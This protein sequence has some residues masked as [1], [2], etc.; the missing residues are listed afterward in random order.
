MRRLFLKDEEVA[1]I[2]SPT[3]I[4]INC[5]EPE[6]ILSNKVAEI[7]LVFEILKLCI[8]NKDMEFARFFHKKLKEYL[9]KA[10]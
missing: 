5:I 9:T 6:H 10:N 4:R 7:K 2:M 3:T 8:I 1:L